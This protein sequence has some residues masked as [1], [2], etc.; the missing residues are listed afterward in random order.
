MCRKYVLN[1]VINGIFTYNVN[2]QTLLYTPTKK[3]IQTL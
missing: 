1:N 3:Q 2:V